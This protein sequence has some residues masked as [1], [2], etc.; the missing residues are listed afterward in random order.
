ML[1]TSNMKIHSDIYRCVAIA[2]I[3]SFL[4]STQ[5]V[6]AQEEE[7]ATL[8]GRVLDENNE[9]ISDAIIM[10]RT[11]YVYSPHRAT[12]DSNGSF[13]IIVDREGWYTVGVMC[14]RSDT[15]GVDYVP[16]V[17][18]THV[19]LGSTAS[20]TFSLEKGAS[21]HLDEELWFVES[22]KP[23]DYCRFTV[24]S[25]NGEPLGRKP[26]VYT[27][28]IDGYS[29]LLGLSRRLVVVPADREVVIEVFARIGSSTRPPS[30]TVSRTFAIRGKTGYFKLS[31]GERLH[32]DVREHTLDCNV[33]A[34]RQLLDSAFSLLKDA[35]YA[36]FLVTVE[37]QDLLDAYGLIDTSLFSGKKGL[38]DESFAKLRRAYILT[39]RTTE[40]LQ[41][42]L[43]TGSQS[44]F[45]LSLFFVFIAS[46]S[47][48]L[49][50]ERENRVEIRVR[51]IKKLSFS[52]N[53][54]VAAIF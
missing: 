43:Q 5:L 18:E 45:I 35:D 27:Y 10:A 6:Y 46:A 52:L 16:S 29:W 39:S 28:G 19:Q 48:Y 15:P 51:G 44:A 26:S 34:L 7:T 25:P 41:G 22:S 32:V 14:N 37:R 30:P 47:A 33:A 54:L 24:T 31:Q 1:F 8:S 17:W 11:R 53:L 49:V 4:V 9:P 3:T 50:T 23:V 13:Q 38:Y 20:F 2:F 12:T 42:L 36:G 21:I 40:A